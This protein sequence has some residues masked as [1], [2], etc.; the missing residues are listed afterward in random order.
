MMSSL[1]GTK[2][3]CSILTNWSGE[4]FSGVL[5]IHDAG[6]YSISASG[7][8]RK[9]NVDGTPMIKRV[10]YETIGSM[11]YTTSIPKMYLADNG[12]SF[13][14]FFKN[15]TIYRLPRAVI[16]A[17]SILLALANKEG[18]TDGLTKV[19]IDI[20]SN[21]TI[22]VGFTV[23]GVP[24]TL[25]GGTRYKGEFSGKLESPTKPF[26][27]DIGIDSPSGT[28]YTSTIITDKVLRILSLKMLY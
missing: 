5:T 1:I 17:H 28:P 14:N 25:T 9:I 16:T 4:S 24:F 8:G 18:I 23:H 6:R 13:G 15:P 7:A 3:M 21:S 10:T 11:R 22:R 12:G 27:M 19:V 20:K 2:N 26:S